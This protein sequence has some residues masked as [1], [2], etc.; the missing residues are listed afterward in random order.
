MQ[1]DGDKWLCQRCKLFTHRD[2][3][4]VH[5]LDT[6]AKL[7]T[8]Q[9]EHTVWHDLELDMVIPTICSMFKCPSDLCNYKYALSDTMSFARLILSYQGRI[10]H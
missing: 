9:Q 2:P 7:F 8:H 6:I 10:C 5:A 4:P 3:C 1:L